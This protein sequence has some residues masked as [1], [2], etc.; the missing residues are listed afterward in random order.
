MET[1]QNCDGYNESYNITF[2]KFN[3]HITCQIV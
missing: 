2:C 1:L 3:K